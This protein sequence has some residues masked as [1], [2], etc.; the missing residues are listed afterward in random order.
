VKNRRYIIVEADLMFDADM[1]V[2][3]VFAV[4][5]SFTQQE[6]FYIRHIKA[7]LSADSLSE[8]TR[9]ESANSQVISRSQMQQ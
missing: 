2:V 5:G 3:E 7:R 4:L 8:A 9:H 6:R 1:M